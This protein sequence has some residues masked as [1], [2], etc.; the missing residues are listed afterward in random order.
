MVSD[1]VHQFDQ[2]ERVDNPLIYQVQDNTSNL[3]RIYEQ[4]ISRITQFLGEH[5]RNHLLD[6]DSTPGY[7]GSRSAEMVRT[8]LDNV[9]HNNGQPGGTVQQRELLNIIN[10]QLAAHGLKVEY[11]VHTVNGAPHSTV[12]IFD[13]ND[14]IGRAYRWLGD[15]SGRF[16]QRMGT[17]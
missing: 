4:D 3:E 11:Y 7:S 2:I 8:L 17:P 5:A 10:R 13:L 6:H 1:A 12:Q 16:R 9:L 15:A 14:R